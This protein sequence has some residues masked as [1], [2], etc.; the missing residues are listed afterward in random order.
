MFASFFGQQSGVILFDNVSAANLL[1]HSS[2]GMAAEMLPEHGTTGSG[3]AMLNAMASGF[4]GPTPEQMRPW[5]PHSNE[6]AKPVSES[7]SVGFLWNI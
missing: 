7:K 3:P 4:H 2:R 6:V 5:R 1:D